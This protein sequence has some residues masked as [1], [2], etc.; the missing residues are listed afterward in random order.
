MS[1]LKENPYAVSSK[2]HAVKTNDS[3][4]NNEK[5]FNNE[6]NKAY[7]HFLVDDRK[8]EKDPGTNQ[9]KTDVTAAFEVESNIPQTK[10]QNSFATFKQVATLND[11]SQDLGSGDNVSPF[12][13]GLLNSPQGDTQLNTLSAGKSKLE[14]GQKKILE[15]MQRRLISLEQE[16]R[17]T[18][19]QNADFETKN[20]KLM[21][22]VTEF[23]SEKEN[24]AKVTTLNVSTY[25]MSV[26]RSRRHMRKR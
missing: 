16:L 2:R 25:V 26:Y 18:K 17:K 7:D 15:S 1:F 8:E 20:R 13:S 9:I 4:K 12:Q 23:N 14:P 24:F 21:E 3:E 5:I 11:I 6:M 10:K 19:K 22:Q